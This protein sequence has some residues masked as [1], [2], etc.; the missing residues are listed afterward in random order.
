MKFDTFYYAR[1]SAIRNLGKHPNNQKAVT[2]LIEILHDD[3]WA[4][5]LEATREILKFPY[6][7]NPKVIG[8]ILNLA[9]NDEKAQIRWEILEA[10][11]NPVKTAYLESIGM[12]SQLKS[13]A[14]KLSDDLSYKVQ[15]KAILFLNDVAQ[16]ETLAITKSKVNSKSIVLLQAVAKVM[17]EGDKEGKRLTEVISILSRIRERRLELDH[18][19]EFSNYLKKLKKVG[20]TEKAVQSGIRFLIDR[21]ENGIYVQT[22]NKALDLLYDFKEDK[23][24]INLT[25][26]LLNKESY[27]EHKEK[28]IKILD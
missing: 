14:M 23:E 3:F 22:R 5:R 17:M 24:V 19:K 21:A 11:S 16:K 4:F 9:K 18:L 10:F 7:L 26:R 6:Q 1:I 20:G 2:A 13:L 28:L 25:L 8:Q 27:S 12:L 15:A